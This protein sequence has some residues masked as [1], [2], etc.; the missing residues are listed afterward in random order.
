VPGT[1]G[2]LDT[3]WVLSEE[4]EGAGGFAHLWEDQ[5]GASGLDVVPCILVG[6]GEVPDWRSGTMTKGAEPPRNLGGTLARLQPPV[7]VVPAGKAKAFPEETI[8]ETR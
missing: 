5:L 2:L 3:G 4:I 6:E 7:P 1:Q 8:Y